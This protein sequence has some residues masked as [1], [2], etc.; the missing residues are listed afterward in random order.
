[1]FDRKLL[2]GLFC[3][4]AVILM[5]FG[6]PRETDLKKPHWWLLLY[7]RAGIISD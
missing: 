7:L 3:L 6:Y 1:M 4:Y 5:H 2:K